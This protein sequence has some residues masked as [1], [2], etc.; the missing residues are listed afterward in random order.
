MKNTIR[1]AAFFLIFTLSLVQHPF[2]LA[3]DQHYLDV[4]PEDS[5]FPVAEYLKQ[6]DIFLGYPDQSFHPD[7]TINRAELLTVTVRSLG[8][9]PTEAV[10]SNC[11][12]DVQG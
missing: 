10:Y 7:Q 9:E 1:L 3:T 5:F 11:F 6:E 12:V 8:V 4:P 2:A